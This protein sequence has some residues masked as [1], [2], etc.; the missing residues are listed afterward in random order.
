MR[1]RQPA[2]KVP[3]DLRDFDLE[4]LERWARY[5]PNGSDPVSRIATDR[6]LAELLAAGVAEHVA[7]RLHAR[8][9]VASLRR[10]LGTPRAS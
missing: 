3:A 1:R 9:C 4:R 2:D 7:Y 6:Y 8:A 10:R 5:H